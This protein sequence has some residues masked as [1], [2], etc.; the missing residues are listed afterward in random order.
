MKRVI[1]LQ[2]VLFASV[3]AAA[4]DPNLV[5]WWKFDEGTGTI[6]YDS[7]GGN[8]GTL[9]NGPVWTAGQIDDALSFDG[10]DD[11]V[12]ISSFSISTNNGA[13]G[14]WFETSAD[15]TA[16][17]GSQ[18]YLISKDSQFFG[19]LT[20]AG[21]GTVPY[22]IV[23]ETNLQ[24]D[25]FVSIEG[26][27]PVGVWNHIA[28]SF[29]NKTAK[30]YLNGVLIQT[31]PVTSS[32]LTLTRIG[33]RTQEF[34]NGTIDDVRIYNRALSAEEIWQLY[35][36]EEVN[37][38]TLA[39]LEITG[40]N[41]VAE[42]ST[43][44]YK[45]I[46]HYDNGATKDVTTLAEWRAE[47]NIVAAI[48]AG[49]LITGQALYPKQKIKVYA[50]Y[51]EEQTTVDAEK[52]VSVLA[53]CPQ[54]N[55]LMFDG[56]N[57]YVN[58]PNN[59]GL[60]ITGD[61]TISAWVFFAK[62]GN[63]YDGS[64]QAII[65]K[66]AANGRYNNPF[67]FRTSTS[68][69]PALTLI[70]ADG[71]GHEY[72][73]STQPISIN[74]WHHVLVRVENKVPDFYVDGIV[75]G[76]TLASFTKT[77]T[78]NTKPLLIGRRDDGL[79]L[80]GLID[81]VRIYN[82]ALS[83]EEIGTVMYGKPTGSDPNLVAYWNFDEG[84]GQTAADASGHGNNGTLGSS[85]GIDTADPCWV[86]SDVPWQCTTE[87][88][89]L[90]NLLGA[91]DDKEAAN[92]LIADAK[93]KERASIQLIT[94]L[95]KQMNGKERMNAIKAKAQISVAIV[96]EE[97]ASRQ[98]DATIKRLEEALR[99][100]DYEVDSNSGPTLFPP[101]QPWPH[102]LPGV[103]NKK[104]TQNQPLPYGAKPTTISLRLR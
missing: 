69:Q 101:W 35:A 31:V 90:R 30:T 41:E 1:I 64:E 81:D 52:Q 76:K 27:V 70:R 61:I 53:I 42:E 95:Q 38:P 104:N 78:G 73:F 67:D 86:E 34:F 36:G 12:A 88:V 24:N 93:A 18:G 75:T 14:L 8:N 23:G 102:P 58:V 65:T 57:D 29:Y 98:I 2:I 79:Y 87:Q 94:D 37:E 83:A 96:Q 20:V 3:A 66:C 72:V 82:R 54:G 32:S 74:Q 85:N 51:T 50:E 4:T 10:S 11:Y 5:G 47:P 62:G 19:Y 99:L 22:W 15:F 55:A 16:N 39:G 71:S 40:P 49:Q 17:Y 103:N 59:E 28:V 25:Y 44:A 68:P 77:P 80:G 45:A 13:I 43:A 60:N 33:G 21:N 6:V 92:Q 84:A 100:L 7:A 91:T 9:V 63:G 46:A 97:T 48:D 89:M 56:V 26:V